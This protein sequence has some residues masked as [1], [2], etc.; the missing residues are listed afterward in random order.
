MAI[1]TAILFTMLGVA[2]FALKPE[3]EEAAST[4]DQPESEKSE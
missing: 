3:K 2:L 1:H 4:A